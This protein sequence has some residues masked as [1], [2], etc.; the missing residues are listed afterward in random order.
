MDHK[1]AQA[2]DKLFATLGGLYEHNRQ[3]DW[4]ARVDSVTRNSWGQVMA[5]TASVQGQAGVHIVVPAN[6]V[7]IYPGAVVAVENL[8]SVG[9]PAWYI[10]AG[11]MSGAAQPGVWTGGESYPVGPYTL[12][13]GDL[14]LGS[15]TTGQPNFFFDESEGTFSGR[16]GSTPMIVLNA[17]T[18]N[19]QLV[20]SLEVGYTGNIHSAGMPDYATGTGFF[21]GS[22]NG[23]PKISIGDDNK[24][25]RWDGS[26]TG[27]VLAQAVIASP[28]ELEFNKML[29][30]MVSWSQFAIWEG[31]QDESKRGTPGGSAKV[32]QD[33]LIV[34][35]VI[36]ND[37]AQFISKLYSSITTVFSSASTSVGTDYLEDTA[38]VWFEG[39]YTNYVLVDSASNPLTITDS[40]VTPRRLV[41]DGTPA[42]GAYTIKTSDPAYAICWTSYEQNGGHVKVQVAFDG[43]NY[44]TFVDTATS[45]DLSGGTAAVASSGTDYRFIVT[46]TNSPTGVSPVFKSILVCTDPSVWQG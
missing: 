2:V 10:R 26:S 12:A 23:F 11:V 34:P 43:G 16:I 17:V 42:A 30:T 32:F 20:G 19:I 31:F 9:S 38:G 15:A 35:T 5:A 45:V 24:Y 13:E 4:T 27:L 7:D 3:V 39:Q 14:L 22:S 28:L 41:V 36:P 37:S 6:Q 29:F 40:T 25:L 21:I 33:S 44:Q 8:G 1:T 46:L 18:G